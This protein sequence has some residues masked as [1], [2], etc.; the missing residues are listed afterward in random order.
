MTVNFEVVPYKAMAGY[1]V[2]ATW[3]NGTTANIEDTTFFS[4]KPAFETE[5]EAKEW[6]ANKSASWLKR[7]K[8]I[9]TET[10]PTGQSP[11]LQ[12]NHHNPSN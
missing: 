6:I 4:S 8:K 5:E 12:H 2:R 3:P 7:A 10:V 11:G 9:Q 1:Y